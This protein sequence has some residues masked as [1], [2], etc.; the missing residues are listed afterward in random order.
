MKVFICKYY[1]IWWYCLV[2]PLALLVIYLPLTFTDFDTMHRFLFWAIYCSLIPVALAIFIQLK[3]ENYAYGGM[4]IF[5][6]IGLVQITA[7]FSL[8]GPS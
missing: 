2:L 3:R 1:A 8:S 5:I 6:L 4:L 7:L